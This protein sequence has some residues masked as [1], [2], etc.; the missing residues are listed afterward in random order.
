[1]ARQV[2]PAREAREDTR[3]THRDAIPRWQGRGRGCQREASV[4]AHAQGGQSA[5]LLDGLRKI[6]AE[7]IPREEQAARSK[8]S[9][10]N[11]PRLRRRRVDRER[12]LRGQLAGEPLL[13]RE[14]TLLTTDGDAAGEAALS[15]T[16]QPERLQN[17]GDRRRAGRNREG[18]FEEQRAA[19]LLDGKRRG[20]PPALG[21]DGLPWRA[22]LRRRGREVDAEREPVHSRDSR[23]RPGRH[24][25]GD[26]AQ[27]KVECSR[28]DQRGVGRTARASSVPTRAA[29]AGFRT[30][31]PRPAGCR[32][33]SSER[34]LGGFGATSG[35]QGEET[36]EKPGSR[37]DRSS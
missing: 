3:H 30:C 36:Q 11:D 16:E 35:K 19:F 14:N 20:Q 15:I 34:R 9:A 25:D 21:H 5:R 32:C 24:R 28:T 13:A 4:V 1:M 31:A 26:P 37:H 23:G 33:W 22:L 7:G 2:V 10:R 12:P 17:I 8:A 6:D 27:A 18:A 29:R